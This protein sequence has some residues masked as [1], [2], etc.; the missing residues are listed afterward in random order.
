M[1]F[2]GKLL[3]VSINKYVT[4]EYAGSMSNIGNGLVVGNNVGIGSHCFLGCAGGVSIGDD[5][6]IGNYVSFHSGNHNSA[7]PKIAIRLQGVN[8]KGIE[9]GA[10]CWIRAKVTILDGAIIESGCVIAAGALVREGIYAANSIY[11]GVPAKFIKKRCVETDI[12]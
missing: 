1:F 7:D 6:I 11:G 4:I 2:L 12:K 5:V 3:P 10:N 8:R 9:V